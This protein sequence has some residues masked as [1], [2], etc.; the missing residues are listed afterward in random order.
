MRPATLADVR[1]VCEQMWD[2]GREELTYWP[3]A[4]PQKWLEDWKFRIEKGDAVALGD[5]PDA[6]LG[7]D[8]GGHGVIFTAF[9]ATRD[10]EKP[11]VG[12]RIT[13]EIR[14]AIPKLM[15][16]RKAT[17]CFV[18]SLCVTH[19][20]EKWFRL[21]GFEPDIYFQPHQ[22]GPYMMRRFWRKA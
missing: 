1:H 5:G 12:S 2:R 21:L 9:Q 18:Y 22:C 20:A 3:G 10:F 7:C 4:T 14:R 19:D 13:K 8:K 17:T 11:G 16:E 15:A 6:I